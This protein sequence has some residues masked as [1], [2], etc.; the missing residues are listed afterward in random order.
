MDSFDLNQLA[1]DI[2][3]WGVELGFNQIGITDTQLA[4]AEA[5][6]DLWN[7][8]G[9]AGSMQWLDNADRKRSRPAE[10][11]PGTLRVICARMDYLPADTRMIETLK[12][13]TKGYISRYTLGRDYH[14]LV[15]KRLA[16]LA[17]Q[18]NAAVPADYPVSGQHRAFVDSAPIMERPLAEKAGLGWVGKHTLVI[19]PNAGSWFFLGEIFSYLPLPVDELP[20][21]NQCG[22]CTAC[23][24]V[25]P[26]DAF[27]A[28]YQLDARRCI[29][30][31]TIENK[32]AIPLE[33][34]EPIGN[35]IFGCDD[36][37][38]ICPWNKYA[39]YTQEDDFQ[40][41]HNLHDSDLLALFAWTE[42]EFLERTQGSAIRRTGFA[43]WQRNLAV[44]LGNAPQD[45]A[46]VA[47]LK[48]KRSQAC[49]M[50]QEHIDWALH[51]QS[52][53]HHQR[54]RKIKRMQ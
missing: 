48:A 37:Q 44:A 10:L 19:N 54:K 52:N 14:K 17:D 50:V 24:K 47:A 39:K 38:A 1:A 42:S 31:L 5:Q 33:F 12:N 4:A 32:D 43:G 25:C 6:L 21:D 11:L 46:I 13:P 2:K 22:E 26:T 53:P 20:V 9:Y 35:R 18:I 27:V 40:P 34:R 45:P 29:S 15:R 23:L 3:R 36:C 51:Q 30:Y 49:A 28:P 8:K 41:R 7:A 16:Q